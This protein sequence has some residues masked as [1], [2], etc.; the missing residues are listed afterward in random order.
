MERYKPE[1][2]RESALI[3]AT[4]ILNCKHF[5]KRYDQVASNPSE[6]RIWCNIE[7]VDQQ[8][9]NIVPPPELL[10]LPINATIA[11]LKREATKAFQETY[12]IFQRFQAEELLGFEKVDHSTPV[13]LLLGLNGTVKV[14]GWCLG[15]ERK[16]G[17]FRMERGTEMWTVDCVCGTKD[18]DGERM[19]ACDSCSMWQHTRCN[20]I[21]D[22]EEVPVTFMCMKCMVSKKCGHGINSRRRGRKCKNSTS[23]EFICKDRLTPSFTGADSTFQAQSIMG[24]ESTFQEP[25]K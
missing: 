14:R 2:T 18:D 6:L 20:K 23:N 3:S 25:S 12:L 15:I 11:S 19:L 22:Y 16:L 9:E 13:M 5:V 10:V 4:N 21:G 17:Q 8:N 1:A 24:A 7:M